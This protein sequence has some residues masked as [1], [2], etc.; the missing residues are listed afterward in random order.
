MKAQSDS[1]TYTHQPG[2]VD[3]SSLKSFLIQAI[4]Q[5]LQNKCLLTATTRIAAFHIGGITLHSYLYKNITV[6]IQAL[7]TLQH[8]LKEIRYLIVDE[9]SMLGQNMLAWVDK[10][11]CQAT[12]HLDILFGSILVTL[13][14]DFAQ[15][16]PVGDHP[17]FAPEG[18]HGHTLYTV[19]LPMWS[20]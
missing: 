14:G 16:P 18:S 1:S 2:S 15:L 8:K 5:L 11:L 13:I 10:R 3:I 9:V 17:L 20:Y 6:M 4:A 7:T 19:S 12:T